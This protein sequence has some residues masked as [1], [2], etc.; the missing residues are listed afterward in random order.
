MT[1]ISPRLCGIMTKAFG[2]NAFMLDNLRYAAEKGPFKSYF[3]CERTDEFT[4][5]ELHLFT[6]IPIDINRGNVSP[7]EVISCTYRMYRLFRSNRFD[8]IQY[9]SSNAGLYASIAGWAARIPVRIYCQWGISYTDYKG[10]RLWFYKLM[11]KI[12]CFFS[13]YVQPDSFANLKFAVSE[14]LY[15]IDKGYVIGKGSATGVDMSKYDRSK[16]G[17]W[18]V[19]V[20]KDY[21]IP[22]YSM[23]FGFVGRLVPEKGVNELFESF[24]KIKDPTIRLLV[25]G[26]NYETERLNQELWGKAHN[27]SRIIF[28]GS[29][30]NTAP[31]YAAMDFLVLPSYREGFGAVVL[32]AGAMGIPSICSNIKGPTDFVK[33]HINGIL[34]E[35][36]SSESL[37]EAFNDAL[38]MSE[39]E[40]KI[41]SSNA[42]T[43]VKNDFDAN[44][45]RAKYLENRIELLNNI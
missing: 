23:V 36:M 6:Y 16:F 30:S 2:V 25:V 13:T 44:V 45:F 35:P 40:Y 38:K 3:I 27:D 34:C 28:C 1:K 8:I 31:Y 11:E 14:R 9:A 19:K 24:L 37:S 26:P 15:A 21:N 4:D 22:L 43:T 20:R 17:E 12:T 10:L 7:L 41:L 32:E 39:K 5:N 42:F 29:Q 33:H 18:R